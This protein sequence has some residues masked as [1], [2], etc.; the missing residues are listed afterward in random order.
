MCNKVF[1]LGIAGRKVVNGKKVA[2][3]GGKGVA[4]KSER[5]RTV[6]NRQSCTA[7]GT[8]NPLRH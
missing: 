1:Q 5:D 2:E 3:V 7:V 8:V 4:G 6:V